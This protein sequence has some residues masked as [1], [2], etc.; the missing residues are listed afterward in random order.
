MG[1]IEPYETSAGRRY[2]VRYRTPN[3]KQ[4]TKRG[5]RTKRDADLYLAS[6]EVSKAKGEYIEASAARERV[7]TVGVVWLANQ[8]HLKPSSLRPVE[9]AWRVHVEPVWGQVAVG[10]IRHSDVQSWISRLSAEKGATTV[11]RAY[12]V[13]AGILD[14][15]VKDRRLGSNPA[16]GV[17]LPRKIKKKHTY[18]TPDQVSKVAEASGDRALLVLVLSYTGIR[19]GEAAGLRVRDLDL[20]RR[21]INVTENAVE[22]GGRIE[23]GTPKSHKKR[24]VPFPDSLTLPLQQAVLGKSPADLV[25]PGAD[26]DYMRRTRVSG[27]S[28]SWFKTALSTAAVPAMTIHDLRHTAASLAVSAGA[29]VKAIQR[30]FG[31]ASAAMTLDVYSDLF[32]D[33]LDDVAIRL[34]HALSGTNVVKMWSDQLSKLEQTPAHPYI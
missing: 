19:W 1:T 28:R 22:V 9:V 23:V 3:H 21:R 7:G 10:D 17:N 13:L 2:R 4:T 27:G 12:G 8:T 31:H 6:V 34:D 26:G 24:S 15:A 30:M 29:N 18:L 25:F 33:D 11:L 16:R 32:D 14:V 5:F 20:S